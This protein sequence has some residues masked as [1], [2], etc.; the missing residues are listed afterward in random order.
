[1]WTAEWVTG[2]A[3]SMV[4]VAGSVMRRNRNSQF[5]NRLRHAGRAF[6]LP[7][8]GPRRQPVDLDIDLAVG[9]TATHG[10][11]QLRLP[12]AKDTIVPRTY[13]QVH[14]SGAAMGVEQFEAVCLLVA[15]RD[16]TRLAA[17]LSRGAG[18]V[19][20]T[21]QTET[22]PSPR[23]VRPGPV[24]HRIKAQPS[25]PHRKTCIGYRQRPMH[26]QPQN[27][28]PG[29][30]LAHNLQPVAARTGGKV[31]LEQ[32]EQ[33]FGP[34]AFWS[35]VSEPETSQSCKSLGA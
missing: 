8:T 18:D 28:R 2:S 32:C 9:C 15:Y 16:H 6:F 12:C 4:S 10:R 26:V 33:E 34:S 29:L 3:P 5:A 13:Q 23:L 20:E 25:A 31:W 19:G 27:L 17:N 22:G 21:V 30:I 11:E 14:P 24:P 35:T 1:M 7:E